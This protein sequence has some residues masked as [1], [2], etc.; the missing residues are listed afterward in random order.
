MKAIQT[1]QKEAPRS[2][3]S[4]TRRSKDAQ[5]KSISQQVNKPHKIAKKCLNSSFTIVS[6]DLPPAKLE[7][8]DSSLVP[9][10]S[11]EDQSAEF[12]E[13]FL[14]PLDQALSVSHEAFNSLNLSSSSETPFDFPSSPDITSNSKTISNKL[15]SSE[16]T[17]ENSAFI[18]SADCVK[19]GNVEAE[20]SV[21][22]LEEALSRILNSS[23]VDARSKKIV[24]ALVRIVINDVC[25]L[26]EEQEKLSEL[27]WAK[28]R[29]GFFFCVLLWI[30]SFSL[31][32]FTKVAARSSFTDPPPT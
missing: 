13:S 23:D 28:V 11:S 31:I 8:A 1:P 16:G 25:H 9:E 12:S 6:K 27:A 14:L 4:A 32:L 20:I 5:M 29:I 3:E 18:L 22:C 7:S 24:N 17:L 30:I 26:P 15:E 2:A 10:I 21:D 19:M